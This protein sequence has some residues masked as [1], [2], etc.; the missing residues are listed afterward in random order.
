LTWPFD[1][2]MTL[3]HKENTCHDLAKW[4]SHYLIFLFFIT[5]VEHGK[6]SHDHHKATKY[7]Q[8]HRNGHITQES[9][10]TGHSMWQRNQLMDM[11]TVGDKTHSHDS[12]CIYS[13]A[14]LMGTLLSSLCQTLTKSSWLYSGSGVGSLTTPGN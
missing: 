5:R 2:V 8:S 7:D 1:W 10:V 14:N 11:R 6:V 13:V 9:Q 3:L 4:L 12:N